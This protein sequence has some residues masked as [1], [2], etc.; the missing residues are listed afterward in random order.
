MLPTVPTLC[1]TQAKPNWLVGCLPS[2]LSSISFSSSFD[3]VAKST[4]LVTTVTCGLTASISERVLSKPEADRA[5]STMTE[6]GFNL[7]AVSMAILAPIP[8]DAP[9]TRKYATCS[10]LMA[11]VVVVVGVVEEDMID[12]QHCYPFGSL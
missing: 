2:D 6:P 5:S 8:R 4:E 11:V 10:R 12:W 7:R 1:M 9:V 3:A